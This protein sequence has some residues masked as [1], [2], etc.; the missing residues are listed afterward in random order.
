MDT[1]LISIILPTYNGSKY[2]T[3]AITSVLSQSYDNIELIIINDASTDQETERIILKLQKKDTR[4]RYLKNEKN[5][6]RS[7]SKNRGVAEAKGE[8]IAFIDDDDIWSDQEKLQKQMLIMYN[9]SNIGMVGTQAI[10]IDEVGSENGKII[11]RTDD[12]D[13]RANLLLTNQFI[14]SS[15][16]LKKNIFEGVGGFNEGMNLC[17]DYDLWLR[18][19]SI[20]C[21]ANIPDYS[22][23][24][25]ARTNNTTAKNMLRMKNVSLQL[26]WKYRE[27]FP[28]IYK[29]LLVRL[30]TFFIPLKLI[31]QLQ[32]ILSH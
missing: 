4:I 30:I 26:A 22:I 31:V 10:T 14:Q 16:L 5:R 20:T 29:A 28:G 12:T 24:Y 6:E 11:L 1:P 17:E 3:S 21:C 7:A 19:A 9:N 23:R 13:I 25:M 32:K 15:M 8:F 27:D 2:I 18:I